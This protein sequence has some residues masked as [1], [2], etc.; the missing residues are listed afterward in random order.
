MKKS[1]SLSSNHILASFEHWLRYPQSQFATYILLVI[2]EFIQLM[3]PLRLFVFTLTSCTRMPSKY[4]VSR[5]SNIN[6]NGG[7]L[8]ILLT[9]ERDSGSW[10]GISITQRSK[11]AQLLVRPWLLSVPSVPAFGLEKPKSVL[12]QKGGGKMKIIPVIHFCIKP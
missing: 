9:A 7:P 4:S 8:G 2:T 5:S 11:D 1:I 3:K 10:G 6:Q 12:S